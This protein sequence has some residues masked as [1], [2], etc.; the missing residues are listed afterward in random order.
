M[1]QRVIVKVQN[2][3]D[4][5][6]KTKLQ[7]IINKDLYDGCYINEEEYRSIEDKLTNKLHKLESLICIDCEG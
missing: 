4:N 6:A 7:I 5:I 1:E 2:T 3:L